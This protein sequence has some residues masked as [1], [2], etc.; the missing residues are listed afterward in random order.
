MSGTAASRSVRMKER[1]VW[2]TG[3]ERYPLRMDA[4]LD[5]LKFD[6]NGLIPAIV[7]DAE[8]GQVL[9]MAW[10]NREAV[11]QTIETKRV[12]YW[13]RSRQ[14]FWI[15]GE[16]SGHIQLLKGISVDCDQDV[17]LLQVE[18][19]GAACHENFRTCFYRDII[20][21]QLVENSERVVED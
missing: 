4:I 8:N 19:V 2:T 17:L 9:M 21:G 6:G 10:M 11:A 18:Q 5:G 15:K 7:Q 14:K 12:T 20:D 16:T 1:R 13:S 3:Q